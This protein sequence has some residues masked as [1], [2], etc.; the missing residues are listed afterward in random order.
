MKIT[1]RNPDYVSERLQQSTFRILESVEL[2]SIATVGSDGEGHINAAYFCYTDGLD[3]YFVS[4]PSTTHCKNIERS[5]R[6]AIA[7]FDTHLPWGE[8]IRGLQLFGHCH[9]ATTVESAHAL[10]THA[11]RFHAYGDYIKAL[12]PF[13]KESSP[14]RFYV[15]QALTL[16]VVDEPEFGEETF[17][18]AE[19]VRS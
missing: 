3:I 1:L 7:V 16:K 11:A 13:E 17:I 5:P 19:V 14:Y 15:F 9:L 10:A 6:V 4:D 2:C 12:S 8:P 18:T